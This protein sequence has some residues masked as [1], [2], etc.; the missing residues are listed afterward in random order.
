MVAP[1]VLDGF[2]FAQQDNPSGFE[3][4]FKGTVELLTLEL[5]HQRLD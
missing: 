3:L 2:G 5:F 4:D 1:S